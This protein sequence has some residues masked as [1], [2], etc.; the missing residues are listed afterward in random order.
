MKVIQ[1]IKQRFSSKN[2]AVAAAFACA[3]ITAAGLGAASR[4]ITSAA[5]ARDCSTNSVDY[6]NLNG[7]CGAATPGELIK[8][9][10]SNDPN[11]LKNIYAHYGLDTSSYDKFVSSAQMGTVYKDGRVVVNGQTVATS[12]WSVG[13]HNFAGRT[14]LTIAGK[15]YY[16]SPTSVSF[17]SDSIP[18]MVM[19]DS[20]GKMQYAVLTAC[21][22]PVTA[23]PK[24]PTYACN[25]LQQTAVNGQNNTYS[26][27]TSASAG[28]GAKIT[29]VVYDFGDGS[30][31][32][33]KTSPSDAV[34]HT[35]TKSST[36][37][38]KVYVSVPGVT[39]PIVVQSTNCSKKVT[40]TPTPP[41]QPVVS[42]DLLTLTPGK[43]DAQGNTPY[44][45]S[46]KASAKNATIQSYVFDF[47]DNNQ[48]QTVPTSAT[49]ATADAHTY[50][51]GTY[52]PSV[53]VNM[54]V[55]GKTQPVTSAACVGHITVQQPEC[56]PGV[57]VG[58]PECLPA[59]TPPTCDLLTLTANGGAD[60]TGK[61]TYTLAATVTPNGATVQSYSFDFGDSTTPGIVASAA[62]TASIAH[63][64]APG[65]YTA[66]VVATMLVGGKTQAVTSATCTAPLTI[67]KPPMCTVPGKEN[68][69]P[70]S[71][72]CVP[73][74]PTCT[75]PSGQTFPVGSKEC[76]PTTPQVLAAATV[77]PNT[78]P[79]QVIGIFVGVSILGAVAHHFFLRRRLAARIR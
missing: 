71:P 65:S 66:K 53:T 74:A 59:P 33:T 3:V 55:D 44:T 41:P 25:A 67:A 4:Q 7:G 19:F 13:R 36:V 57:P 47:N 21:G 5:T 78:G 29:K 56:K 17:G 18:A 31:T 50:A 64:Y 68:L 70:S 6:K 14:K 52:N 45:L 39:A 35:F 1:T 28:N 26:Y 40:V 73:A 43:A 16:T 72:E 42:C 8:D 34:T 2:I 76:T 69:P 22:N 24:T 27:T 15:T 10:K 62:N 54:L 51:P 30:T 61:I 46:A 75:A 58:S 11:D 20:T 60:T 9:I 49:T 37:T 23:T 48:T 77:M 79:G 12:A 32:V 63:A 38:V